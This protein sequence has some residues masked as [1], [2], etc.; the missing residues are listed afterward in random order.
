MGSEGPERNYSGFGATID[1]L[2]GLAFHT[3]YEDE[4]EPVRSGINYADPVTGMHVGAALMVA[5]IN[6]KRTGQGQFVDVSLRETVSTQLGELFMEYS[7]HDRFFPRLGNNELGLAPHGA[8]RTSGEDTWI[9]IAI[10]S[11]DEWRALV[12]V[13]GGPDWSQEERF[14]DM[15]TRWQNRQELDAFINDWTKNHDAKELADR[16]QS[17]G[18]SATPVMK[19]PEIF[20]TPQH[21]ARDWWHMMTPAEGPTYH[22]YGPGWRLSQTPV[23]IVTPPP[24][25]GQHNRE[26]YFGLLGLSEEEYAQLVEEKVISESQFP[27]LPPGM[28]LPPA[29]QAPAS[30]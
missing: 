15:H 17:A 21:K 12:R 20:D 23:E 6:R 8:Y 19:V 9:T 4:D 24:T 18:I 29:P 14:R 11:D 27:I 2:G 28:T 30:R 22:Y 5:L 1:G 25:Y 26:V 7:M 13:M 3:G 16:L 10:N